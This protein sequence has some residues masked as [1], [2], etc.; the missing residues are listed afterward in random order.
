[1]QIHDLM[2]PAAY[3]S[4]K[5]IKDSD[6]DVGF[7][8]TM[9]LSWIVFDAYWGQGKNVFSFL[10]VYDSDSKKFVGLYWET[11][12]LQAVIHISIGATE[13]LQENKHL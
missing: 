9:K 3:V 5:V 2:I 10:Q 13:L 1:M 11:G 6:L 7:S 12:E 8:F 4:I